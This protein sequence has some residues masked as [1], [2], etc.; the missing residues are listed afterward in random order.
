MFNVYSYLLEGL[1]AT[2]ALA[3]LRYNFGHI[4][5]IQVYEGKKSQN[6]RL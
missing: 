6:Q 4:K 5:D 2:E 3:I 1:L